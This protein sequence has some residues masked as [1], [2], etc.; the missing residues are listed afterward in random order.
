MRK[1]ATQSSNYHHIK[2]HEGSPISFVDPDEAHYATDGNFGTDILGSG[3]RCA[4]TPFENGAWWQV[5]L[6][7]DFEIRQVAVTT[8]NHGKYYFY[9]VSVPTGLTFSVP[10]QDIK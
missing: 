2:G 7:Y 10:S 6:K 4:H 3:D 1:E 5:D 9:V 8:E